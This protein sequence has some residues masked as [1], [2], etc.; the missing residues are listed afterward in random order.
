MGLFGGSKSSNTSVVTDQRTAGAEGI[1]AGAG[2]TVNIQGANAS[3]IIRIGIEG[4]Q[5]VAE[6]SLAKALAF[7][8]KAIGLV[9]S[10]GVA[11]QDSAGSL[12][13]QAVAG[14]TGERAAVKWDAIVPWV[15]GG[16]VAIAIG[17]AIIEG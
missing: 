9:E 1:T 6:N 3:D 17:Y 8:E 11:A 5:G 10:A 12:A 4:I 2:G 16:V 15:V 14:A 7:G 13:E